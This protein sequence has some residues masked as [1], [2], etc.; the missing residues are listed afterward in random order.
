MN[1]PAY[2]GNFETG[3]FECYIR[4]ELSGKER[5]LMVSTFIQMN[6]NSTLFKNSFNI[7]MQECLTNIYQEGYQKALDNLDFELLKLKQKLN[8]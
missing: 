3:E 6:Q 5:I 2:R 1:K 7:Y 8:E 4:D